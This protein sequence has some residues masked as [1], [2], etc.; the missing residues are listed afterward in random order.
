MSPPPVGARSA[1]WGSGAIAALGLQTPS[2]SA[3]AEVMFPGLLFYLFHPLCLFLLQSI[4]CAIMQP[5][6]RQAGCQALLW[7]Q[8]ASCLSF[9]T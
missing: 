6:G 9:P 4:L 7:L 3:E 2:G 1:H 5:G 8:T